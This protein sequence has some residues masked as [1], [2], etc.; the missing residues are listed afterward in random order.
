M[1]SRKRKPRSNAGEGTVSAVPHVQFFLDDD[2][3]GNSF[4]A[5]PASLVL[6]DADGDIFSIDTASYQPLNEG[7]NGFVCWLPE[8]HDPRA[9]WYGLIPRDA[10]IT[11]VSVTFSTTNDSTEAVR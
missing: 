4:L 6:R 10:T 9:G 5:V 3:D 11:P 7:E 8:G 2:G 1:G